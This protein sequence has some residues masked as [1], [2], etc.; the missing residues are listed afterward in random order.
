[1]ARNLSYEKAG[2][3][4]LHRLRAD[5]IFGDIQGR[6]AAFYGCGTLAEGT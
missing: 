4:A 3:C 1:M 5:P 2:I 6:A